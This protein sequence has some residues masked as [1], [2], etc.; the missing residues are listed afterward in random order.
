M[1]ILWAFYRTSMTTLAWCVALS[2]L[3]SLLVLP[4]AFLLRHVFD[5]VH[6]GCDVQ[7]LMLAG[8]GMLALQLLGNTL[9]WWSKRTALTVTKNAVRNLRERTLERIYAFSHSCYVQ[10]NRNRLH[11]TLVH[12]TDRVDAMSDALAASFLPAIVAGLV[13]ALVMLYLNWLLCLVFA[14]SGPLLLLIHHRLKKAISHRVAEQ[15]QAFKVSSGGML[16]VLQML[17]LI[18]V[19]SAENYESARQRQHLQQLCDAS[20]A[21]RIWQ[22]G[23]SSVQLT[24]LAFTTVLI[25]I[26]GGSRVA[27]GAMTLGELLAFY[28]AVGLFSNQIRQAV[29]A[30][31]QILIGRDALTRL[32]EFIDTAD[33]PV[34]N[35]NRQ[36]EFSGRV[37]FD[38]VWF[39]YQEQPLLSRVNLE[40]SPGET[41]ILVGPNGSGKTTLL[42]LLLGFYRPQ[43]GQIR[44]D[45]VPFD[46]LDTAHLRRSI[47]VAGQATAL[48]PGTIRDN[49]TYGLTQVAPD[50]IAFAL[51]LATAHEFVYELPEGLNTQVG[52]NGMLLSGGQRQRLALARAFLRRPK[53]L[54]LDEP[55]NH[56]DADTVQ[57]FMTNL[58]KLDPQPATLIIS[59]DPQVIRE[60]ERVFVL[61]EGRWVASNEY[62]HQQFLA[63]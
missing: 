35:G 32:H 19:Q 30:I 29:T 45:D 1:G 21:L 47:A 15:R 16:F 39:R 61:P 40:L 49:L 5:S 24:M 11:A 34:Y 43:R 54:I 7:M 41:I 51:E 55:T 46:N 33:P 31:P 53:L 2:V 28:V 60:A 42:H 44:A 59:H 12:D 36:I 57:Q 56:L 17:D 10:T 9:T 26:I 22:T 52:D 8:A 62:L 23:Y 13:L 27:A 58:R 6:A 38:D 63:A 4:L 48:F 18:R 25:L 37:V 3:H 50:E 14:A 20:A